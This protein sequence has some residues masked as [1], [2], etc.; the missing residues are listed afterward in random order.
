M[1][2]ENNA[3]TLVS[4][5]EI[6]FPVYQKATMGQRPGKVQKCVTRKKSQTFIILRAVSGDNI[7]TI[8]MEKKKDFS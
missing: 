6:T 7:K 1:A 8:Y 3:F 2:A 4:S 5:P